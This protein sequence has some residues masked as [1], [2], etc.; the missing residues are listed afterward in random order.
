MFSLGCVLYEVASGRE[1]P[2]NTRHKE[3]L[4]QELNYVKVAVDSL[5]GSHS[6]LFTV[7]KEYSSYIRK[8]NARKSPICS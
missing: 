1:P 5:K 6:K 2:T 8:Y 7:G 4:Q 3:D